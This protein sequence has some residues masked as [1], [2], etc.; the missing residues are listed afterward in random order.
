MRWMLSERTYSDSMYVLYVLFCY[1][2]HAHLQYTCVCILSSPKKTFP[3][4]IFIFVPVCLGFH[5]DV[6]YL[7]TEV[8]IIHKTQ[9]TL[10]KRCSALAPFSCR[11]RVPIG[12][13]LVVFQSVLF[14]KF[15]CGS[16]RATQHSL[17]SKSPHIVTVL[18]AIRLELESWKGS[19]TSY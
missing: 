12:S 9:D 13:S 8:Y 2:T 7:Q 17:D 4:F 15:R 16:I 3:L 6:L 18:P 14:F 11:R 10:S 5:G 1:R 19:I